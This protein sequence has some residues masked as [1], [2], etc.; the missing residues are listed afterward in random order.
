MAVAGAATALVAS[1]LMTTEPAHADHHEDPGPGEG[2]QFVWPASSW[3]AAN[4]HYASG[5]HHSGSADLANQHFTPIRP[6]R[7]GTVIR[8]RYG[9]GSWGV[10]I[11]H[12]GP[13]GQIYVTQ[14]GHLVA[15]PLVEVGDEVD[16]DTVLGY[17]GRTGNANW[18]GP[19]IHFAIRKDSANGPA[20]RIPGLEIGDWV[21]SGEH[22]PGD[23]AGLDPI[24]APERTF[25]VRVVDDPLRVYE[26][27]GRA[28][29][30]RVAGL[31]AGDVVTVL[32]SD[33][34]QYRVE[35][36]GQSGWIAHSGTEPVRST[37]FGV[38]VTA[39][40]SA[41]VRR[42]P[43]ED[44]DIIGVIDGNRYL[45]GY[46]RGGTNDNWVR[47]L[48]P[49]NSTTN[50]IDDEADNANPV[51]GCP[52]RDDGDPSFFKYGWMGPAVT[53]TTSVFQART[54]IEGLNVYPN[55]VVDGSNQ[56]DCP[57]NSSNR[58]GRIDGIRVLLT[59]HDTFNG[60][61][62]IDYNGQTAW[63]R[64]WFTAGRQ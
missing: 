44:S 26:T 40:H 53:D 4:D 22:I 56:P 16:L 52:S 27:T 9:A 46:E 11:E 58:I 21:D 60:W 14:Y 55:Q 38:R 36:D 12:E 23:Y 28:G 45:T 2:Q 49:C 41:N 31:S 6:A 18:S 35:V 39:S 24:E 51:G 63:V 34:G 20:M 32:G 48:W 29:D 3:I 1:S 61:Y 15:E 57:C 50:R 10:R 5:T 30:E 42:E 7:A 59:V 64:G 54:R 17:I 47:V 33:R 8:S 37:T 19:H 13:N 62:Q 25:D 43:T